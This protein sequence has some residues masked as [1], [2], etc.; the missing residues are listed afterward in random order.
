MDK[1]KQMIDITDIRV[2][3]KLSMSVAK[4]VCVQNP[5]WWHDFI[6]SNFCRVLKIAVFWC[7]PIPV[8]IF[9][10]HSTT[11]YEAPIVILMVHRRL[12]WRRYTKIK[13][14]KTKMASAWSW[15]VAIFLAL[16]RDWHFFLSYGVSF[17][18]SHEHWAR[19]SLRKISSLLHNLFLLFIV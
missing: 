6:Y 7:W 13:K 9:N 3:Q 18:F 8:A 5:K 15:T 12:R 1:V 14:N 19:Q 10:I 17:V 2:A 16:Q 4:S 11:S